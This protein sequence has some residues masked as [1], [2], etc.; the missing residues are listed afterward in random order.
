MEKKRKIISSV[1]Q[2]MW[3]CNMRD[4]GF[5]FNFL[6]LTTDVLYVRQ[7]TCINLLQV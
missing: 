3:H 1:L 5:I 7:P 4:L 6:T 2:W